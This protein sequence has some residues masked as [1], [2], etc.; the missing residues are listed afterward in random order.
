L[1]GHKPSDHEWLI[2]IIG[3]N[4]SIKALCVNTFVFEML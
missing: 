2:V 4:L 3:L 1:F